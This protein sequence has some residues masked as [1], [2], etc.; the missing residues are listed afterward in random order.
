MIGARSEAALQPTTFVIDMI[1]III[2]LEL[3]DKAR[4]RQLEEE[5]P[6]RD[7]HWLSSR[8]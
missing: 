1:V 6:G 3:Q 5:L 4:R 8:K 2:V 7:P